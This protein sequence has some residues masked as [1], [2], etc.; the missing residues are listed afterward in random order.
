MVLPLVLKS[1]DHEDYTSGDPNDMTE[2]G[3]C[4]G[5]YDLAAARQTEKV[6]ATKPVTY[7]IKGVGYPRL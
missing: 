3:N 2:E 7:K 5:A 4:C 1:D 6:T